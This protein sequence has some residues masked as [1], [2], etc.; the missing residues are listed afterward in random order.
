MFRLFIGVLMLLTAHI[1]TSFAIENKMIH[2]SKDV[3]LQGEV[4]ASH[5][6]ATDVVMFPKTAVVLRHDEL[7]IVHCRI[8][9]FLEGDGPVRDIACVAFK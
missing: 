6:T 1:P 2:V 4:I 3:L 9:V 8:S 5:T 7:G